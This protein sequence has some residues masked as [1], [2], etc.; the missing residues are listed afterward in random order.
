MTT[1]EGPLIE[2]QVR[3]RIT[4]A[5]IRSSSVL[6]MI[7]VAKFGQDL[8]AYIAT[9]P[10][11][12]LLLN[13]ENVDYLSSAVLTELLKIRTAIEQAE[14]Q[15]RLC[16]VS[17]TIHKAF[18]ITNLDKMFIIHP[19]RAEADLKRFERALD[20]AAQDAAWNQLAP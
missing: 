18:E 17:P 6:S 1:S 12:N 10:R 13:F 2:F 3:G 7:N 19:D 15:L 8:L 9:H 16:A 20:I 5:T 11:L 4:I 14:G